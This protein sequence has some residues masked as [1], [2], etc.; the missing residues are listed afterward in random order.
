[1]VSFKLG[2]KLLAKI[3]L[4]I[5]CCITVALSF[6][7]GC[8]VLDNFFGPSDG[9]GGTEQGGGKQPNDDGDEKKPIA[10]DRDTADSDKIAVFANGEPSWAFHKANGYSNGDM[11][12]CVWLGNNI[13]FNG[14]TMNVSITAGANFEYHGKKYDYAGGE[15][16]TNGN[17]S[18][19]YYSVSMKPA[20]CMGTVSSFFTYTSD[21]RWDEIDIE[22]LGKDTTKVQFNYYTDGV[23][24]HEYLYD[25]GFDAAEDFHEY[26][27][28]W[29]S[30]E[31]IWYVD[32]K[33]VYK[34]TVD[35]PQNAGKIM[36]NVW[37]GIGVDDWL[38]PFDGSKLPV[39]AQYKWIGYKAD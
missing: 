35:I 22:F 3:I 28:Y 32:G 30:D 29:Q 1:M 38:G 34:A 18:F 36:T 16:R 21:P 12:N 33:A 4:S 7:T 27:F 19:G 10:E 25:L 26:G 23:G 24:E 20:K 6:G 8:G 17:Y 14:G 11:F 5:L 37:N 31:I 15:Y 13:N 2:K 9:Q 39:T